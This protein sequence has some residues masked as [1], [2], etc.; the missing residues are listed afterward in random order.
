MAYPSPQM[1]DLAGA[2]WRNNAV[3]TLHEVG[4]FR[5]FMPPH[6]DRRAWVTSPA[7]DKLETCMVIPNEWEDCF[8]KDQDLRVSKSIFMGP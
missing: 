8:A 5:V 4:H 3:I 2:V 1:W 6:A 7:N